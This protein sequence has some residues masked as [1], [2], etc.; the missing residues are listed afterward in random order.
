MTSKKKTRSKDGEAFSC[1]FKYKNC[2]LFY[3]LYFIFIILKISIEYFKIPIPHF[4]ISKLIPNVSTKNRAQFKSRDYENE[5][6][7]TNLSPGTEFD[8]CS[9]V[10][11]SNRYR[12][13]FG[14][15][16]SGSSG[17]F[18]AEKEA[19]IR[20]KIR[21]IRAAVGPDRLEIDVRHTR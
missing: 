12:L 9:L 17:V 2:F 7:T 6:D 15:G 10:D 20:G 18:V 3:I 5:M 1:P 4:F 13:D 21:H 8:I 16:S 11:D 14:F 19:E